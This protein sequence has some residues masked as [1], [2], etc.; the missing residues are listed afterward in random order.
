MAGQF[1]STRRTTNLDDPGCVSIE[2]ATW[3]ELK[4]CAEEEARPELR[5]SESMMR[6]STPGERP[7]VRRRKA[8][9]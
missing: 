6:R 7:R 8:G 9:S 1:H 3:R 4:R 5:R 2:D